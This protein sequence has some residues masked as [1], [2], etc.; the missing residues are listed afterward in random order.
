VFVVAE[1]FSGSEEMDFKFVERLGIACLIREG[2]QAWSTQELSRLVHRHGGV[3][4]GGFDTDEVLNAQHA[5]AIDSSKPHAIIKKIKRSPVHAL[6]MDCTTIT[7]HLL[8]SAMRGTLFL[9]LRWL[10]C[11]HALLAVSSATMK[12]TQS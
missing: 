5:G 3:P 4:I 8:K 6:F 7:R 2:M 9:K 10:L 11:A 12:C 1:L